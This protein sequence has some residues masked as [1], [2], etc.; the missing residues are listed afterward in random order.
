MK[1]EATTSARWAQTVR[2]AILNLEQ[3]MFIRLD[4]F[5]I[6]WQ[7]VQDTAKSEWPPQGVRGRC[8]HRF[9]ASVLDK[10]DIDDII[11]W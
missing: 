5:C 6:G 4:I 8:L 7:Q 10:N 11:K 3:T 2:A 9:W 1:F